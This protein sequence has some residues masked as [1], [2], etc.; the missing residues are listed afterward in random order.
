MAASENRRKN[1]LD[2]I[3]L[4][5]DDLLQF[6]LHELPMLAE[7]LENIAKI[8][9]LS[10]Q[11]DV[12]FCGEGACGLAVLRGSQQTPS[13]LPGWCIRGWL[14][15]LFYPCSPKATMRR[16]VPDNRS[17][18]GRSGRFPFANLSPQ[19][20]RLERVDH[21]PY[22]RGNMASPGG[23]VPT[24]GQLP[25]RLPRELV[26]R[27]ILTVRSLRQPTRNRTRDGP[28]QA[29]TLKPSRGARSQLRCDHAE[30][31]SSPG[32]RQSLGGDVGGACRQPRSISSRW[33][34][35]SNGAL[36]T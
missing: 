28:A 25:V 21:G 31:N 7:F 4:T 11:D 35:P 26:K 23:R 30:A 18:A 6:V 1:L 5:D 27:T 16:T 14:A 9:T 15:T 10:G 34:R 20:C 29:V 17:R 24:G 19:R 33:S 22:Y 3:R 32:C 8:P 12:P 13:S 2:D 36:P